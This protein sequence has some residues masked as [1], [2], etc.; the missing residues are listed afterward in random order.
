MNFVREIAHE[1]IRTKKHP[2]IVTRFPPEPNGYLHI[3]HAK[4]IYLNFGLGSEFPNSRT[5]LRFDDTNPAKEDVE[6]VDSIMQDVKWL[7]VDWGEHLY[8]A[9]DYF[10][11]I[12]A[13]AMEL[14]DKGL[15]YVCELGAEEVRKTRGTL[16]EPGKPS[17]FRDRSPEENRDLFTRM[18]AGEFPDG[19]RTLRAKIDVTHPNMNM[20][21]PVIYRI[22]KVPH[23]RTG[24]T[25]CIY[26]T[27][28]L[29]HGFSDAIEGITH[30]ICT[31]EFEDHRP[32]YDWLIQNVSAPCHPRQIEFARLNLTY[33]VMSKRKLLECVESGVVD[34][35][36]DPRMPTI[37]GLRR[38]GCTPAGLRAFCDKLGVTKTNSLTDVAV[39][40]HCIREDLNRTS[41]RRV[42]VLQPLRLTITNWPEGE[43]EMVDM[44]NLPE[45]PNAGTRQVP[46]TGEVWIE[47][48]D[49]MEEPPPNYFRLGPG[50]EVR[51]RGAFNVTCQEVVK[52]AAGKVVEVRCTYDPATRR[53]GPKKGSTAIHWLSI[54]HAVTAEVRLY[55]RLFTL[56]SLAEIP[57]D[58]SF[59]DFLNTDSLTILADAKVEAAAAV[60]L[61]GERCQFERTGYFCVDTRHSKPGQPVFNRT[62]TLKDTWAK[63]AAKS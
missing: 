39:L 22:K 46:F 51:L 61:P 17:P 58:K 19:S 13:W 24:D 50:R 21:D 49:F 9:S 1:D 35:W 31:L 62:V 54:P 38:L 28:D 10:E 42:A 30:S 53:S 33:T 4:S 55:E 12:Y 37:A 60:M 36:D 56:E 47:A 59:T 15:A 29:A 57:E 44:Q 3:G 32:L 40:D 25:W 20:R 27:Y 16:T 2:A 63:V 8:H 7:G 48:E 26:P 41:I 23:D 52:D 34:G 43:V 45:D 11:Q 18:R 5:H 14:V 6:Y